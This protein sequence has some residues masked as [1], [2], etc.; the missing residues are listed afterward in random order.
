MGK[1]GTLGD[2]IEPF[3]LARG[4]QIVPLDVKVNR[5]KRQ[6]QDDEYRCRGT[7]QCQ[8]V[9]CFRGIHEQL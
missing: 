7:D 3:E 1:D 5:T 8:G 9:G 6:D 4:S 2:T